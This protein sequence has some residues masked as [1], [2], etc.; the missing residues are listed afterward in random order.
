ME[1]NLSGI[2]N[3]SLS[4]INLDVDSQEQVAK[5]LVNYTVDPDGIC[6]HI[7]HVIYV[8]MEEI[9]H[10]FDASDWDKA[11]RALEQKQTKLIPSLVVHM[12]P[13]KSLRKTS[14][15]GVKILVD[16]NR[17]RRVPVPRSLIQ[18]IEKN[19]TVD[20][21]ASAIADYIDTL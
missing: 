2:A 8:L 16:A 13:E 21:V 5:C 18:F 1:N 15:Y 19:L 7:S 9:K 4:F 6:E 14:E 17:M 12:L 11:V 3:I 20:H 10:L